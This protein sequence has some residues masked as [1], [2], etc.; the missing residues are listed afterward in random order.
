MDKRKHE[1]LLIVE[2]A[3]IKLTTKRKKTDTEQAIYTDLILLREK[4]NQTNAREGFRMLGQVIR[5]LLG[6]AGE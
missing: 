5:G 3:I 1:L 4:L 6:I 2:A